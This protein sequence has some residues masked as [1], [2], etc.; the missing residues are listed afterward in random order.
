MAHVVTERCIKCKYTDCIVSCP[1][2]CFHEGA[3]M[4][5][6]DPDECIDCRACLDKCPVQAIYPESEVPAK[7]LRYIRLNRDMAQQ[8][9]VIT[10]PKPA[11][12]E[13]EDFR[14]SREKWELFDET[15]GAGDPEP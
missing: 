6:I 10:Y 12:A 14:E 15:P 2:M 11:M 7:W 8:W 5:V 1:A 13:S 4:L 9:P 3:N